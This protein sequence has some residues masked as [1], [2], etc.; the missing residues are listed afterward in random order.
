MNRGTFI[1]TDRGFAYNQHN[2]GY[3]CPIMGQLEV[4]ATRNREGRTR[5]RFHSGI[6]FQIDEAN[7][8]RDKNHD[9]L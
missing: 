9:D 8:S 5:W 3:H 6:L 2:C 1:G 7:Q 4:S